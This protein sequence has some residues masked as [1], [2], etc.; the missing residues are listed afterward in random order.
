MLGGFE[1]QCLEAGFSVISLGSASGYVEHFYSKNGYAVREYRFEVERSD[2]M[3][4]PRILVT[5]FQRRQAGLISNAA[6]P[7]A[8]TDEAKM[9]LLQQMAA[10]N[11]SIIY[12]KQL[13]RQAALGQ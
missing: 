8:T 12:E 7:G 11:I 4:S 1:D 2:V 3:V 9:L 5:R 6:V 13:H 10:I